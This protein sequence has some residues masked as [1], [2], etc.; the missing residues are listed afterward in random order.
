MLYHSLIIGIF[1]IL[2][3]FKLF[4]DH[5]KKPDPVAEQEKRIDELQEFMRLR[6]QDLEDK[7]GSMKMHF[8]KPEKDTSKKVKE[9]YKGW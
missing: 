4:L 8:V 5:I 7:I 9:M 3:G 6:C 2:F 1:S